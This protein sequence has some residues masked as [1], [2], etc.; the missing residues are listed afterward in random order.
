MF[1]VVLWLVF[2]LITLVIW[3]GVDENKRREKE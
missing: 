2:I 1:S 3:F